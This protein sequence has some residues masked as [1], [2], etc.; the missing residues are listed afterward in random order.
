MR[1]IVVLLLA[2]VLLLGATPADA[3][4]GA[5]GKDI[6]YDVS[7]KSDATGRTWTG[8]Q[9]IAFTNRTGQPQ[10]ELYLRLW[11]NAWDGCKSPVDVSR[12]EGGTPSPPT[13]NCT[14][15]KVTL[16]NALAP[17]SRGTIAF[18]VAMTAPDRPERFGRSAAYSFFGNALPVLAVQDEAGWHLEPDVGI[19]E[20]YYTL[21][22]DFV[23][24]LDHP[25]A[26]QVPATGTASTKSRGKVMTTTSTAKQ[27]R[28]FAW[29]VGPFQQSMVTSPGGVKVRM[30][31][32]N[33]VTSG[34]IA[35]ARTKGVA[36]IDDFSRRFGHYPYGEIDL[37][38]N[39]N[40]AS[41]SG[42]EYP[43]FVLLVAPPNAEGPVVHELA[44]QWWYGI[45]GNNE[46]A[47]PWLDESFATYST[48]LHRGDSKPNCWPGQLDARITN[49]MGFWK[50]YG[51]AWSRYVYTYGSCLLH[52]LER[53]IGAPAMA[54]LL[55]SYASTHWYGVA[56]PTAFKSA[57]QAG[58]S[59]DLTPFW[60]SHSMY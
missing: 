33:V 27:V 15:Q 58:S 38:L 2:C 8:R 48:D 49:D 13:V 53:L 25:A 11:G 44:H 43:G 12:F 4:K 45:V 46:Y 37:V 32:T 10:T 14:A 29:A 5:A 56:T 40:W 7:L 22:A 50:Q 60:N 17:G 41:F 47:D 28:D 24:R 20:S 18:D 31:W 42:M 23:V 39:D 21:A 3:A 51:A 30:W 59:Q 1:R 6:Q 34:A 36:A 52:D 16:T 57:A 26:L 19:G 54:A 9:Q 55:K 35:D